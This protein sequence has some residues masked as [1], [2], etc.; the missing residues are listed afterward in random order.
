VARLDGAPVLVTGAAGFLGANLVR[1][2]LAEGAEVHAVVR[3]GAG[4]DRLAELGGRIRLWSAELG[5]D[6]A[7]ESA[8]AAARPRFAFHLA[9]RGGHPSD[10]GTRLAALRTDVLGT[11]QL[12]EALAAQGCERVL[13]VG[14]SLEYGPRCEPLREAMPLEPTTFRGTGKA[15]AAIVAQG[16]A[17]AAGAPVVVLRPFSVYGPW[18]QPGRLVP[19]LLRAALG[20]GRVDL[21][22]PGV[23]RDL[24]YVEDVVEACLL[25]CRAPATAL[26]QAINVGSGRQ[27]SNEEVAAAVEAVTGRR[28][29][30]TGRHPPRPADTAH[31][32]ADLERARRLLGWRP[33][34]SLEEGLSRTLAW[35][36]ARPARPD[37]A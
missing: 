14:S 4:A 9:A 27:W 8:V 3:P 26:G 11:A 20:D 28:L 31:W 29:H 35:L 10:R 33:R 34:R 23:R 1:A 19:T 6:E 32:V 5:G 13:H 22:G 2:L 12:L 16:Y 15:A 7:I 25:A 36:R 30:V 21:T 37:A 24:V 17:R 18:E